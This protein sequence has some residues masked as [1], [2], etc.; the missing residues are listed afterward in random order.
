MGT[1]FVADKEWPRAQP[2]QALR[3]GAFVG[4]GMFVDTFVV[5]MSEETAPELRNFFVVQTEVI[6]RDGSAG[7]AGEHHA[8]RVAAET[9]AY[10]FFQA[11]APD[12]AE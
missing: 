6:T 7:E 1:A 5:A 8:L 11:D 9:T 12:C 3:P 10:A 2:P 4:G